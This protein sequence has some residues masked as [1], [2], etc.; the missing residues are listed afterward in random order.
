MIT[1]KTNYPLAIE[2]NDYLCPHGTRRDNSTN[3]RFNKK[4]YKLFPS[5][6]PIKILDLGCSGGGFIQSVIEDGYI[7]V[8]LEGSD[9][10][11][12]LGRGAWS[13]IPTLFTADITKPF[14]ILLNDKHLNFDV[15]TSFEVFEHLKMMELG[16]T[17]KNMI[18]HLTQG[19]IIILGISTAEEVINDVVLH[20]TVKPLEWWEEKFLTYGLVRRKDVEKYFGKQYLR[21]DPESFYFLLQYV[22]YAK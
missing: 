18:G 2:S 8:G 16:Q 10:S 19:G 15:I 9:W 13:K 14:N 3:K 5:N 17:I 21:L 12:N 11:K 6:S 1:L 7:G 20:H 22:K 4:L